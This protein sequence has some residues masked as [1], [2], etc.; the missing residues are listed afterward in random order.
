MKMNLK[1]PLLVSTTIAL[2]FHSPLKSC[3]KH[4]KLNENDDI[5]QTMYVLPEKPNTKTSIKLNANE[6]FKFNK[7]SKKQIEIGNQFI[8]STLNSTKIKKASCPVIEKIRDSTHENLVVPVYKNSR[9]D[10]RTRVDGCSSKVLCDELADY[11]TLA[12]N[13]H[14]TCYHCILK[15]Q[16][17]NDFYDNIQYVCEKYFPSLPLLKF[18]S[19]DAAGHTGDYKW[20]SDYKCTAEI[21]S[22]LVSKLFLL[23]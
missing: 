1:K 6:F 19:P 14:D 16:C 8:K 15:T 13:R 7:S 5:F 3:E 9:D 2:S 11:F 23:P 21:K 18:L 22:K 12:C 4:Y 20:K 17:D 10:V